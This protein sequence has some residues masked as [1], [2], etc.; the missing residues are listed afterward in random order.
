M[1]SKNPDVDPIMFGCPYCGAVPLKPCRA[2]SGKRASEKYHVLRAKKA[3]HSV[4][5]RTD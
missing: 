5:K 1:S 4:T 3:T 2:T